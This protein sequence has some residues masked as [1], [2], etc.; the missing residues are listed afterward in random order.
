MSTFEQ[1]LQ[2]QAAERDAAGL[3]RR[4]V[5][6]VGH[7]AI[8]LAG[9]DYLGLRRDPTVI[10]AAVAALEYFGSGAG[11]SRLV[12]G[13]WPIHEDLETALAEHLQM[14]SALVF[15]TGYQANLAAMTALADDDT[16]IVSDAHNHAS[17]ID[18]ARLSRAAVEV[19]PHGDLAAYERALQERTQARAVIVIESIYSVFGDT[20]P[21][22][23]LA[24]MA[25]RYDALL[26]VDEAHGLGVVGDHGE[27]RVA[28]LGLAG[29]P[30]I[31]V[32]V[33]L[34]KA[35]SSQGGA[36][37]GSDLVRS[38]LI[39]TARAFIYDTG[40]AP[41]SAGAALGALDVLVERPSLAKEVREIMGELAAA[42]GVSTPAGA[43]LSVAMPGPR[44][45]LA[46]VDVCAA[47]GVRI[48]CFRPPSTPDGSS[49]LRLTAHAGLSSKDVE[50][51]ARVLRTV[52]R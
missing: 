49:R 3:T 21:V 25:A 30:H 43:V 32:T 41:V 13:T 23:E 20:S 35:L 45:A 19:V 6:G 2:S 44:E 26:V 36:V 52:S 4:V 34:A 7:Q 24:E 16:L 9:N 38:H 28:S 14:E 1:Y 33:S 27:G 51:C 8:D 17:I 18:G 5:A 12:T 47:H 42:C 22:A 39:N 46:A 10:D 50:H 31:V 37:L 48:G 29:A 15:S 40:L 11:A